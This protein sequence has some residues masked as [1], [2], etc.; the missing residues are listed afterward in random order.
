MSEIVE[1]PAPA[2]GKAPGAGA[3]GKALLV[4]NDLFFEAKIGE[5]FKV[6]GVPYVVARSN[7]QFA[8]RLEEEPVALAIV[9]LG[10]RGIDPFIAIQYARTDERWKDLPIISFG[11]HVLKEQHEEARALGVSEA[12]AKSKLDRFL[13]DL[14]QRHAPGLLAKKG[15]T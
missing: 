2:P 8:R 3:L 5:V 15:G 4:L 9:D 6:L 12:I 10:A 7:E 14:V 1:K 11:A 13:P